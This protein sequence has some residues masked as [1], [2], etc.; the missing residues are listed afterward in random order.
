MFTEISSANTPVHQSSLLSESTGIDSQTIVPQLAGSATPSALNSP[1]RVA[2]GLIA[3]YTFNEGTGERIADVSSVG[4]PLDLTIDDLNQIDWQEGFLSI[5]GDNQ[6]TAAQPAVK[7]Y[8]AITA[9]DEITIEAWILP[10]K[11][12]P[13]SPVRIIALTEENDSS[14]QLNQR[15]GSYE[16]DIQTGP[17]SH[18][19]NTPSRSEVST[20]SHQPHHVV[21]TRESDGDAHLYINNALVSQQQVPGR[22]VDDSADSSSAT[23]SLSGAPPEASWSGTYDLLAIYNQALTAEEVSQNFAAGSDLS[24]VANSQAIKPSPVAAVAPDLPLIT[25]A[26][27]DA[28]TDEVVPGFED[29]VANGPIDL[30]QLDLQKHNIVARVNPEHP[31]A[32]SVQSIKFETSFGDRTENLAPYAAFGDREGDFYGEQIQPGTFT[33]KA[34]PYSGAKGG[35]TALSEL[36]IEYTVVESSEASAPSPL[37]STPAEPPELP[38]PTLPDRPE[39][40][41]PSEFITQFDFIVSHFD[42]NNRDPDDVAALPL[43]AALTSAAGL[44]QRS[45]FFYNNNVG[46]PNRSDQVQDMRR[47][48]QF[49]AQLGIP[50]YDYQTDTAA[51]TDELVNIF[52]SGQ[53]VLLLEGGRMEMT[54]RALAQTEPG[55]LQNITLLSHSK[56]NE[57]YSQ[58][59]TRTWS[60]LQRDFPEVTFLN[61]PDQNR[62]F[63]SPDWTWLDQTDDPVL[64]AARDLMENA[65]ASKRNDPSDAGMHF[66]AFTGDR[67]GTPSEAREFFQQNPPSFLSGSPSTPPEST[68]EPTAP[69]PTAPAPNA[70]LLTFALVNAQTDTVVPGFE[71]LDISQEINLDGLDLSQHNIVALVNPKHPEAGRVASVQFE[72]TLGNRTENVAPYAAFGDSQGDFRGQPIEPGSFFMKATAYSQA[73]GQGEVLEVSETRYTV[74]DGASLP[75]APDVP[76]VPQPPEQPEAP[77]PMPTPQPEPVID[78]APNTSLAR[79]AKTKDLSAL[80]EVYNVA[81]D[82]RGRPDIHLGMASSDTLLLKVQ[83]NEFIDDARTNEDFVAED[84]DLNLTAD[85]IEVVLANGQ[86]IKPTAVHRKSK[87]A[88]SLRQVNKFILDHYFHIELPQELRSQENYTVRFADASLGTVAFRP[89]DTLSLAIHHA[90][91]YDTESAVKRAKISSWMG[92]TG[93]GVDYPEDMT[94]RI[95]DQASDAVVYNGSVSLAQQGDSFTG[96]EVLE[97]DFSRLSE[98]GTYRIEIDGLGRSLP[99]EIRDRTWEGLLDLTLEGLYVHRAFEAMEAPYVDFERPQNTDIV[100]YQSPYS[101]AD[102]EFFNAGSE[103]K[104]LPDSV[105]RSQPLQ[106]TGG[107]FD[108]GDFDTNTEHFAVIDSLINLY[109]SNPAYFREF[110]P[111]I[112]ESGN[113]IPDV[114]DEALW[115]MQLYKNLQRPD[116]AVA[117]GY[118]FNGTPNAAYG[119]WEEPEGYLYAPDFWTSHT[120]AASA[121]KLSTALEPYDAAQAAD[122]KERAIRAMKWAETEFSKLP[123][124]NFKKAHK[125][126]NARQMAAVELYRL[127]QDSQYHDIFLEYRGAG[128]N[129]NHEASFTYAQLDPSIYREIDTDW[130]ST[131]VSELIELGDQL[132]SYGEQNGYDTLNNPAF[133]QNW[134]FNTVITTSQA[135]YISLAHQLTG[136]DKYLHALAASMPFG[137]GMNPDNLAL[138]TGTVQRGLAYDEPDDVLHSDG[139]VFDQIPAG[140]TLYGFYQYPWFAWNTVNNATDSTLFNTDSKQLEV[141]FLEAF[142]DYH[143][144]VPMTEYTIHQTIEDQIFA[145]GY[146]ASQ[147][148][149]TPDET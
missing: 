61:I 29:L 141:P 145:F 50:T 56:A 81:F 67:L 44:T 55:N 87:I 84:F 62:G 28:N 45:A 83:Q 64:Q 103:F 30:G 11:N 120:F 96:A 57:E 90:R 37:P 68:P 9:S 147:A 39:P 21:F 3:L 46:Q 6:I 52:N 130:Q 24:M 34:T 19:L 36:S 138:T 144:M 75:Q 71:N 42:G 114:L 97:L 132:V 139:M 4:F 33:L 135:R 149:K 129:Q 128:H 82:E 125:A 58:G 15:G 14:F 106:V 85:S 47:S 142:S 2:E 99:F 79:K 108:A 115:G 74:S 8:E 126:I 89:A 27:V 35:G 91:A 148:G 65:G 40:S 1:E 104:L 12:Q 95:V 105:D 72:S 13:S 140:I 123:D 86:V 26:L 131:L 122:L 43:A 102:F 70:P 118:E 109:N 127:T 107:W 88:D 121:A 92:P 111:N 53:K 77:T 48:A 69:E 16:L 146:L 59:G 136:D 116:G 80:Q 100:F 76:E 143:N 113:G 124:T 110:N 133:K 18:R 41:R 38:E 117:G 63:Q 23:L 49:A 66:Y 5:S 137:L 98:P 54:Y 93:G 31:E 7:L 112:P 60:D 51:A 20:D 134:G 17:T 25:L 73:R 78:V 119:S 101:E 32:G 22:L 94:F 10:P